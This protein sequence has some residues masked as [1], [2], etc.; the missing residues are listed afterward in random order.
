MIPQKMSK[1]RSF[2]F[3][4][5][6][7]R[8]TVAK[9]TIWQGVSIV[10][11]R[12]VKALLIIYVARLLGTEGYGVFS[13]AVGLAGFF[14]IFSDIG[15]GGIFMRD[16][17]RD[18]SAL[19]KYFSTAL[20]IKLSLTLVSSALILGV[21]P[22]ITKIP[23]AIPLLP[24][25]ALLIAFDGIRD[26][27]LA[28]ARVKEKMQIE[29]GLQIFTNVSITILGLLLIAFR[30]TPLFLVLGYTLGSGVGALA[31]FWYFRSYFRNIRGFFEKSLVIT[32]LKEAWP[33][34]FVG[35][36]GVVMVNTDT[37]MLGWFMDA[38]AVGLYSAALRPVQLFY[39]LPAILS[40]SV[41][42]AFS[43]LA[44][45]EPAQ[46]RKIFE[47]ALLLTFLISLPIVAGGLILP[48]EVILFIFGP[49][50]LG[51]TTAFTVLLFTIITNFPA[52]L[53]VNGLFAHGKQKYYA[54]ALGLGAL[55]NVTLNLIFIPIYGIAGA[56]LGTLA[57]QFLAYGFM[58][59]ALKRVAP[60]V[61]FRRLPRVS[62]A[63]LL[64]A[65]VVWGMKILHLHIFLIVFLG[66]LFY[67]TL[68]FFLKEPSLENIKLKNLIPR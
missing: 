1:L 66:I 38:R 7:F 35:A 37:L 39:F 62:F 34:A 25:A 2:L 5:M 18:P 59:L 23:E 48:R 52:S 55:G 45:R 14:A 46:F 49:A 10:V 42:P 43:R 30:K 11:S 36:L 33:F 61:L 50:Y 22:F 53:L 67:F 63:A 54:V 27:T 56:A 21:S 64:M 16:A 19:Q 6:A 32:I 24:L 47:T 41:F 68:L 9:N 29:A 51:A 44:G 60:F 26:F 17:S 13:Y 15:V 31:T 3:E 65:L 8:Q 57:A 20:V 4:N 12:L 58:W 40:V 28:L